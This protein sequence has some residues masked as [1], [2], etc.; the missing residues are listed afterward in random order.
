MDYYIKAIAD[1]FK[2]DK[3]EILLDS[4]GPVYRVPAVG[5]YFIADDGTTVM[6]K[7]LD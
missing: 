7:Y 5:E 6:Y 3:Y 4:N 1:N 2:S